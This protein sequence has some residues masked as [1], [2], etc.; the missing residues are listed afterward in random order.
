MGK[1]RTR[2]RFGDDEF[3]RDKRLVGKQNRNLENRIKEKRL[4]SALRTKNVDD[5]HLY[6]EEDD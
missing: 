5:A 4:K 3:D 6:L 2:H 1:T